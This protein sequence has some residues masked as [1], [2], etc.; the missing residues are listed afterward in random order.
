MRNAVILAGL[1]GN[2]LSENLG[3]PWATFTES[4]LAIV[5]L[6]IATGH[7]NPSTCPAS[8]ALMSALVYVAV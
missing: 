5:I 2:F 7:P 3:L 8:K 4:D 1:F 6:K